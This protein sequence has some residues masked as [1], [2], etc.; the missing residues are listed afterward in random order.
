MAVNL[1]YF[2]NPKYKNSM[3][4]KDNVLLLEHDADLLN[5]YILIK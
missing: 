3:T 2:L 5:D 4:T 1:L